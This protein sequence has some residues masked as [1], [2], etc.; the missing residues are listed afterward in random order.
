MTKRQIAFR[1]RSAE[2]GQ[3]EQGVRALTLIHRPQTISS[4]GSPSHGIH[5]AGYRSLIPD[6]RQVWLQAQPGSDEAAFD[7]PG[8]VLDFLQAVPDDLDQVG[9]A[10]DGEVGQ[11]AAL[12]HGPDPFHR[13]EVRGV[14]RELEHAQPCLGSGEGTQLG[15][16]MDVEVIPDQDDDPAGQLAVRGDQQVTVLTPG[17][18]L[19]LA[20]AP[21]VQVQPVN[22]AAALAGLVAGQ[23]G[24]GDVPGAAQVLD[25]GGLSDWPD[26]SSKTIRPPRAAAVLLP[27]ARS[28]SS[29]PRWRRRRARWPGAPPIWHDQPRRRSRYQTPGMVYCTPNLLATRSPAAQQQ[30]PQQASAARTSPRPPAG[31][32][33]G[34]CGPRRLTRHLAHTSYLLHTPGNCTRQPL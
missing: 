9:E 23:P 30:S 5:H 2:P 3:A 16:E 19:G 25:R 33:P 15:A 13:V 29:T 4:I 1:S 8:L 20:L 27:G 26:S 10:G 14:R 17:E 21:P 22:Q 18:R 32:A 12:E 7:K 24:D 28:P 11:D 6:V 34:A 31:P